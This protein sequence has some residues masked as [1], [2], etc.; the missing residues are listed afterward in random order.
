MKTPKKVSISAT[1][2]TLSDLLFGKTP[3]NVPE[4][5]VVLH[6]MLKELNNLFGL[7]IL[8]VSGPCSLTEVKQSPSGELT[9]RRVSY[10]GDE[11]LELLDLYVGKRE[12]LIMQFK[13]ISTPLGMK[14]SDIVN[15]KY[16]LGLRE[17]DILRMADGKRPREWLA[18]RLPLSEKLDTAVASIKKKAAEEERNRIEK[19]SKAKIEN[20]GNS[21]GAF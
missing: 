18:A 14:A 20:Y 21:W 1:E 16:E 8:K 7:Q 10:V 2:R 15:A 11:E 17:S 12:G 5:E 9:Y 4:H 19:E 3:K 6:S 13:P